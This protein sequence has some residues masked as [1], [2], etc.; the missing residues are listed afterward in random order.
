M[1][2]YFKTELINLLLASLNEKEEESTTTFA[3]LASKQRAN[4]TIG[5]DLLAM[6]GDFSVMP[7]AM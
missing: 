7:N 1:C 2:C 3:Q 6:I 4:T 5:S